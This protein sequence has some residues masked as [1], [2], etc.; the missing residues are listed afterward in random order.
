[1]QET[2]LKLPLLF[3]FQVCQDRQ[4]KNASFIEL[5]KCLSQCNGHGVR[6]AVVPCIKEVV[7]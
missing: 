2:V 4:C 3:W 6:Y 1:M 5:E 7:G